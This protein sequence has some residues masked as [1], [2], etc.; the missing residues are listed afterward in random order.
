MR[1]ALIG[2][3]LVAVAGGVLQRPPALAAQE[4]LS[5]AGRW[6]LNRTLSQAPREIGFNADWITSGAGGE[7]SPGTSGGRGRRGSGRAANAGAF[8]DRPESADDAARMRQLTAEVRT[9]PASVTITDAPSG[10]TITDD[11]GQSRTFHPDG[12]EEVLHIGDVPLPTTTRWDADH[13]VILYAVEAGRQLRYT[14]SRITSPPQLIVDIKFLEHGRGDEVRRVYEPAGTGAPTPPSAPA[15]AESFADVPLAARPSGD[16]VPQQTFNQKP[17]AELRGITSLGLV[18]ESLSAQATA[19]GLTQETLEK[20]ATKTLTDAGLKVLRN[21]DEDTYIYVEVI[22][23]K[24]SSGLCVSRYDASLY[25]HTT[26]KLSYQETPVLV[27]VSLL[28]QGGI[29]G[30]SP[31]AHGQSVAQGLTQYIEQ[32]AARIRAANK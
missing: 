6:T 30:G 22:T 16:R 32:F 24:L 8:P 19:C 3:M 7:D 25:T 10:I 29:A 14:I 9:P 20:A 23:T 1:R 28:H 13:L 31:A 11:K 15:A 27:Q 17:D 26:T 2:A 12:R 18:V 4:T 5:L 21:S